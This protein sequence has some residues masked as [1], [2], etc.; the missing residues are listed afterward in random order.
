MP[1]EAP[2]AAAQLGLETGTWRELSV[3]AAAWPPEPPAQLSPE[4][5]PPTARILP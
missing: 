3:E 4:H 5:D 1:A 2:P